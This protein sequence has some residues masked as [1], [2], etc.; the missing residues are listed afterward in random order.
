MYHTPIFIQNPPAEG[1][2]T[3]QK[4]KNIYFRNKKNIRRKNREKNQLG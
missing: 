3:R 4:L 2:F 1:R